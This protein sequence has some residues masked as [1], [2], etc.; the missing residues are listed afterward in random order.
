MKVE[1]TA[2]E[3]SEIIFGL[4]QQWGEWHKEASNAFA[5]YKKA[6]DIANGI[7]AELKAYKRAH[8]QACE[9]IESARQESERE[10]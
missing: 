4:E 6:Q 7:S 8:E 9:E 2:Q 1:Y 5:R 10:A 3:L